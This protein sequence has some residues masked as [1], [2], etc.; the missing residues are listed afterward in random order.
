MTD[1]EIDLDDEVTYQQWDSTDRMTM[2]TL[3]ETMENFVDDLCKKI[4]NLT[5][6]SYTANEQSAFLKRRKSELPAD[7]AILILDFAENYQYTIQGEVQ[8]YHW[9]KEY[10]SLH[11]VSIYL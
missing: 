3:V 5:A 8:A 4:D 9:S 1:A 6:H 11:P 10:C 7:T 2:K